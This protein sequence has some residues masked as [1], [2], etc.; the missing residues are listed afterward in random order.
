M[1]ICVVII[2]CRVLIVMVKLTFLLVCSE[3]LDKLILTAADLKV[4]FDGFTLYKCNI[5]CL[6][7]KCQ[8][9]CE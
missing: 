4:N 2:V 1:I 9:N 7:R 8:G 6:K 3:L 5:Q